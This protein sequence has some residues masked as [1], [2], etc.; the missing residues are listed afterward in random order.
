MDD[1]INNNLHKVGDLMQRGGKNEQGGHID[2]KKRKPHREF[3]TRR[4]TIR[5]Q[6]SDSERCKD[7]GRGEEGLKY[8]EGEG[9]G[10]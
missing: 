9:G 2:Q 7:G 10:M 4:G 8:G 6:S 3:R 5:Q 1:Y